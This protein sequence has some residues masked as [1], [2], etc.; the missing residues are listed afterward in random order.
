MP[1]ATIY[2]SNISVA[3]KTFPLISL[4]L[5]HNRN[6]I[7]DYG[8]AIIRDNEMSYS[9]INLIYPVLLS[10]HTEHRLRQIIRYHLIPSSPNF[11]FAPDDLDLSLHLDHC[12]TLSLV[13]SPYSHLWLTPTWVS[14]ALGSCIL[15][16]GFLMHSGLLYLSGTRINPPC[17]RKAF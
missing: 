12:L 7:M 2:A 15:E 16:V 8:F 5:R 14:A 9:L 17:L 4:E 6:S 11:F 13:Y 1:N 3:V 10:A